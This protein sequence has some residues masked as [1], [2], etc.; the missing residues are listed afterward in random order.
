M[1]NPRMKSTSVVGKSVSIILVFASLLLASA[2]SVQA[3]SQAINGQI[4]GVVSDPNGAAIPSATV[5]VRNLETGAERTVNTDS[6]GVY[7][8]PLLPLGTYRVTV[9]AANFKRLVREGVTLTTG[10]TATVNAAL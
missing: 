10:Q 4:E 5:I 2:A 8:V 1:E 6:D 9:E 3:Q 7:R